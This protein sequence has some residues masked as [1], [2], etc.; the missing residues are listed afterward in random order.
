MIVFQAASPKKKIKN[1]EKK[2]KN[3]E[4]KAEENNGRTVNED[5]LV[6]VSVEIN[7]TTTN[8]EIVSEKPPK[9]EE[10]PVEYVTLDYKTNARN[11]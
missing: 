7:K 3:N 11:L 10:Q 6:Y 8:P 9:H 4:K 5:G 1:T 2:A